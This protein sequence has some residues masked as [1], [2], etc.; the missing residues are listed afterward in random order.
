MSGPMGPATGG[1]M[2]NR[3]TLKGAA[4]HV[5]APFATSLSDDPRPRFEID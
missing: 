2:C 4:F 3:Y 1:G 5:T